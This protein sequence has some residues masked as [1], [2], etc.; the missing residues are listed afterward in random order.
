MERLFCEI[1]I[2]KCTSSCSIQQT[3]DEAVNFECFSVAFFPSL[4]V[5]LN[6]TN[7]AEEHAE[8]N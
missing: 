4:V 5:L 6:E 7:E 2:M 1:H 8:K 3:V